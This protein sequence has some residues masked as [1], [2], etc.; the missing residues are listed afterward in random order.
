M[1]ILKLWI[2][3]KKEI[4]QLSQQKDLLQQQLNASDH[5]P[6]DNHQD[7]PHLPNGFGD[8]S[9]QV[10]ELLERIKGL[11]EQNQILERAVKGKD[12]PSGHQKHL[13][14]STVGSGGLLKKNGK[15]KRR[16]ISGFEFIRWSP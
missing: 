1:F 5:S 9:K 10:E 6:Q 7:H 2:W 4:S 12:R 15:E 16:I 11:Q 8:H 3:Q 13:S 14:I